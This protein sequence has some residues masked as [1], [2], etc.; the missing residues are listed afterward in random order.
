[1][2]LTSGKTVRG[3]LQAIND[4]HFVLLLDQV[5]RPMEIAY[6]EVEELEPNRNTGAKVAI[7]VDAGVAVLTIIA[8]V[9]INKTENASE[10]KDSCIFCG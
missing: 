5:A 2:K 7:W 6:G 9:A 3:H 4:D 1:M 8:V 10:F